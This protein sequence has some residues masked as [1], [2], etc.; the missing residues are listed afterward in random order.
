MKGIKYILALFS[1]AYALSSCDSAL[2]TIP[3]DRLSSDVFWQTNN[4]ARLASNACYD[5]LLNFDPT[6]FFECLSDIG[7][8]NYYSNDWSVM[9]KGTADAQATIFYDIWKSLYQGIRACNNYMA[10]VDKIESTDQAEL[11]IYTAEVRTLRAFF[12]SY[13]VE[14]YGDAPLVTTPITIAES[15]ELTRTPASEIFAFIDKEL[16]AAAAVLPLK[17]SEVGR[18]TKGA[19]LAIKARTALYNGNYEVAAKAAKDIMDSGVYSLYPEYSKLFSYDAENGC[20]VLFDK[21]YVKDQ[22]SNQAMSLFGVRSLSQGGL[23]IAPTRTLVDAYE[24]KN[25]KLITE[26]GSGYDP[27]NPYTSR[28]PRLGF[29]VYVPGCTLPNGNIYNP[30]P[31]SG[32]SDDYTQYLASTTGFGYAK[33]INA[34]DIATPSNCGINLIYI[35]YAEVLLIYAE[36]KIEMNN[37]DSSVLDA[38][39]QIRR[40]SD[41]DMPPIPDGLSQAEMRKKVRHERL[42]ELALE[43]QRYFDIKRWKIGEEV[44]NTPILCISYVDD[45]GELIYAQDAVNPKRWN[46]REYYWAIPYN[47]ILMNPNLSQNTGW[48]STA[49]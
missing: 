3:T 42:V 13:L 22:Y 24:M 4:D 12:Y 15:K 41:V 17:Q 44:C 40:R 29:T 7:H 5:K 43:G 39:N 8:R 31:G 10:N 2:E 27:R 1:M 16:E 45:K 20:E 32:T 33:Y 46:S 25:G 9:E 14:L 49:Q 30:L 35:R 11:D 26:A 34:E 28:D 38:I 48:S 23:N 18:V 37:I 47:E 6:L 36:A 19:A 21:Q